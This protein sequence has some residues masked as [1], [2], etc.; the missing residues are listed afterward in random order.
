MAMSK[1]GY[2]AYWN[3]YDNGF[4]FQADDQSDFVPEH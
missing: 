2:H 1:W 4:Y 3:W